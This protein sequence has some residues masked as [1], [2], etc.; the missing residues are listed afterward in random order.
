MADAEYWGFRKSASLLQQPSFD[1]AS[2]ESIVN[3]HIHMGACWLRLGK[4]ILDLREQYS[5]AALDVA[6]QVGRAV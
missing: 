6:S 3:P 2:G 1:G 5:C 4:D